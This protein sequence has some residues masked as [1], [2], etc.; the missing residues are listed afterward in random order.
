MSC[1]LWKAVLDCA[2][3]VLQL[4]NIGQFAFASTMRDCVLLGRGKYRNAILLGLTNC[5]K[6]IFNQADENHF[7]KSCLKILLAINLLE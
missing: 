3:K 7:I 5:A 6:G 1:I 4:N 2:L